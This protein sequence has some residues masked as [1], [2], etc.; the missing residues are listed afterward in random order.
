VVLG[1]ALPD[2]GLPEVVRRLRDQTTT[3]RV[4]VL[5]LLPATESR[6]LEGQA[7][8]AGAN[9]VLWR[10]LDR[11]AL[12]DWI[13]KLLLVPRRVDVRFPVQG[14]VVAAKKPVDALNF[15]GLTR[16]LSVNGML[17]AS[18]VRLTLG[19]DMDLEFTVPGVAARVHLLGRIVREAPQ[20]EWPYLGYGVEF[21]LMS[22][23][24]GEV[25]GQLV[26]ANIAPLRPRAPSTI[27]STLRR[28]D[29]IYEVLEPQA[30][31]TGW[32]AE[33]RRGY[34]QR[35]RPGQSGP[36]YVVEGRS[37]EHALRQARDFVLRYGGPGS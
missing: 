32:L 9:A 13:A 26:T 1:T 2:L 15:L 20:V 25:L 5:A 16:N 11:L 31:N 27:H 37:R 29:W 30:T 34:R 24:A 23:E 10:P 14:S 12:E 8:E 22:P 17:L 3:R 19:A 35:W 18:P 6:E 7:R 33:I 4:S 36:F 21:L 28:G